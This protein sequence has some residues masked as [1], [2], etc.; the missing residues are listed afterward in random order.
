MPWYDQAAW[1]PPGS[2]LLGHGGGTGGC[3]AFIGFDRKQRRGVV[4]LSNQ[5]AIHAGPIGWTLLQ[6]LPLTKTSGVDYA[7]EIAGIGAAL[8]LD[9]STRL[10]RITKVFPKSP[11]ANAGLSAG[12]LIARIGEVSTGGK[13]ADECGGLIRGPVGSVVRLEIIDPERKQTNTVEL[14]RQKFATTG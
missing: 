10:L 5:K 3:T 9:D 13:S 7:R 2:E 8:G 1:N 11:A 12:L 6:G 4:V 14:I